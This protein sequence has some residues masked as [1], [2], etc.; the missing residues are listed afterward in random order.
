M[1]IA[2]FRAIPKKF[3]LVG[4]CAILA[5]PIAPLFLGYFY[6]RDFS[7]S[8]SGRIEGFFD[9]LR[10]IKND[11]LLGVRLDLS[12]FD[13]NNLIVPHNIIIYLLTVGGFAFV[14]VCG[15][16][17]LSI[18][19]SLDWRNKPLLHSLGI[20]LIGLQA[21]PSPFSAYFVAI[22][23]G[24]SIASRSARRGRNPSTNRRYPRQVDS[25]EGNSSPFNCRRNTVGNI[26][27]SES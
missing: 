10:L 5:L 2:S 13:E 26:R 21:V 17:M 24:L 23:I 19:I 15:F 22:T 9:S 14:L 27:P 16:W 11:L 3:F 8:G 7:F 1:H 4:S 20:I 12:V 6:N 18:F 25:L